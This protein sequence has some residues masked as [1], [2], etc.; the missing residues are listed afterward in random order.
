[1]SKNC[2]H[3][4]IEK[5][6]GNHNPGRKD[7]LPPTSLCPPYNG[8]GL[9]ELPNNLSQFTNL[10]YI[11][12][13]WIVKNNLGCFDNYKKIPPLFSKQKRNKKKSLISHEA[14]L[15]EADALLSILLLLQNV[16]K[17]GFL[18]SNRILPYRYH[19]GRI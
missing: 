3:K 7:P 13:L 14:S 2:R 19:D 5:N 16:L 17:I 6:H 10:N 11:F 1:M 4:G 12:D 18:R 9:G 8:N 15:C